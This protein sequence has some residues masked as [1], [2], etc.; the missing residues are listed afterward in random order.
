MTGGA[1]AG[2]VK[3]DKARID[4]AGVDLLKETPFEISGPSRLVL[5][6]NRAGKTKYLH[7]DLHLKNTNY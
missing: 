5:S 2:A 7:G 4:F 6:V 1:V 3:L